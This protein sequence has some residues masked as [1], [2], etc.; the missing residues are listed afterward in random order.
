M[1]TLYQSYI[2]LPIFMAIA[3][4]ED[5]FSPKLQQLVDNLLGT[6]EFQV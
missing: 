1:N 6:D 3:L 4:S 2:L 5:T